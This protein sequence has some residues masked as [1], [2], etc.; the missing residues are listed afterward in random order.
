LSGAESQIRITGPVYR[1]ESSR[2][3]LK[4]PAVQIVTANVTCATREDALTATRGS[5]WRVRLARSIRELGSYGAM[6]LILP[7]G[8]LI[9][10]ALFMLQHRTWLAAR[11][12]RGLSAAWSAAVRLIFPR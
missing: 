3:A 2:L 8:N 5:R 7:G 1:S 12:R 10:L 11:A 9:S 4:D 6:A